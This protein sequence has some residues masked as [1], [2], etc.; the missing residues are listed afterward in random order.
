MDAYSRFVAVVNDE[1]QHSIWPVDLDVPAG[2][3][4]LG[5]PG[6]KDDC[7]RH[8]E[9]VW[10]DIRPLSLRRSLAARRADGRAHGMGAEHAP[11]V[12]RSPDA[13]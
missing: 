3:R 12:G 1:E 10:P 8:V 2:W 5:E 6:S 11:D 4:V 7:L 9:S 13:R